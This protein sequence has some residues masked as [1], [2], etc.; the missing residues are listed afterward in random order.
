MGMAR[1]QDRVKARRWVRL[2][3]E[4]QASGESVAAF[5]RKR[6]LAVHQYYWWQR[7]LRHGDTQDAASERLSPA[8]FVPVRVSLVPPLIEVVHP[9]GCIVRVVASVDV[10]ALRNVLAALEGGEA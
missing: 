4:Q 9:S 8:P 5:C 7:Q 6:Q 10:Q 1:S 3:R 2:F